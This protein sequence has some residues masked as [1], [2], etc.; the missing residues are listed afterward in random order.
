MT[1]NDI[2]FKELLSSSKIMAL[3]WKEPY[4]TLML[5]GKI[6]TRTWLTNYRGFVLICASKLP[7]S[8][9]QVES[10]SGVYQQ[11]RI[12]EILGKNNFN[13]AATC[14]MAIAVARLVDCRAMQPEDEDDCFVSFKPELFCHVYIDVHPIKPFHWRGK[15]G[16]KIVPQEIIQKIE[17]L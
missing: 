4:A 5:H 1:S 10:I 8:K 17:F 7:Y 6:E 2:D 9:E 3:S 15:P 14:G 16:W 11:N 13:P 12:N